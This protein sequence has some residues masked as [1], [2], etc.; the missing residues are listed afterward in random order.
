MGF[1]SLAHRVLQRFGHLREARS[2]DNREI[3]R[4]LDSLLDEERELQFAPGCLPA[5]Q[6]QVEQLRLRL[7]AFAA[8]QAS[9]VAEGWETVLVEGQPAGAPDGADGATMT[10]EFVVDGEPI[11]IRGK[12]DRI[13]R[14]RETGAWL[15][16]DYKSS[17]TAKNPESTHRAVRGN[18]LVWVDLQLP[19]YHLMARHI[20]LANGDP[21]IPP[22]EHGNIGLGYVVLP[23]DSGAVPL[24]LADWS[25][26]DLVEAGKAAAGAIRTLRNGVFVHDPEVASRQKRSEFAALRGLRISHAAVAGVES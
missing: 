7:H 21:L 24:Q 8:W 18:K 26:D 14:H 6:L 20:T 25:E 9:H 5:A 16:L 3:S 13:D 15:V 23:G 4:T 22:D 2:V 17:E 12:I 10:T 1:G 19:M 11:I